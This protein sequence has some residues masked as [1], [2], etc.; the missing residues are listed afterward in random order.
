MDKEIALHCLCWVRHRFLVAIFCYIHWR[1]TKPLQDVS[2][3]VLHITRYPGYQFAGVQRD[4]SLF[5]AFTACY[6]GG[7]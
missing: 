4:F 2:Y 6:R 3:G 5:V 1:L 7:Y